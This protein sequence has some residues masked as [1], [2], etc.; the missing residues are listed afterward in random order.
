MLNVDGFLLLL[1]MFYFFIFL[2]YVVS[3]AH[4]CFKRYV[5]V[6]VCHYLLFIKVDLNVEQANFEESKLRLRSL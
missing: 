1:L 6:V 3:M 4:V 2:R 5:F